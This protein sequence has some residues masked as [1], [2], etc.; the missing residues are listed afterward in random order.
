MVVL[1]KK[2]TM[3]CYGKNRK[4]LMVHSLTKN[5]LNIIKALLQP[6]LFLL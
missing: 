2:Y 6:R 5:V 4:I 3:N 1:Q